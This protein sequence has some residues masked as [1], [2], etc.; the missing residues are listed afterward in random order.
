MD[1]KVGDGLVERSSEG[2]LLGSRFYGG[3]DQILQMLKWRLLRGLDERVIK[4]LSS[5]RMETDCLGDGRRALF[6]RCLE[7][8]C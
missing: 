5:G 2:R 1:V 4:E 3:R 8:T 7:L 6:V